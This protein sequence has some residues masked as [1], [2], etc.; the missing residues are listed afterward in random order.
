MDIKDWEKASRK[1]SGLK[2]IQNIYP[3][4]SPYTAFGGVSELWGEW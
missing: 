4:I 1:F 2:Y 3:N